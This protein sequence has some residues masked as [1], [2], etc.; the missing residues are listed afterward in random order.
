[1]EAG[2]RILLSMAGTA[3]WSYGDLMLRLRWRVLI[4]PTSDYAVYRR[5][6]GLLDPRTRRL[7]T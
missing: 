5:M 4:G 6:T 7:Y 3:G 2:L 1:M